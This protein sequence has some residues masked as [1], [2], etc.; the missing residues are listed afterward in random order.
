MR[1][2]SIVLILIVLLASTATKQA[3]PINVNDPNVID[4]AKFA[5]DEY[6]KRKG[7]HIPESKLRLEKVIRGESLLVTDGAGYNLTLSA[8]DGSTS[9]NY[10]AIVLELPVHH[11]RNLTSFKRING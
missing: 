3:K 1:L 4:V 8:T 9:S 2:Q 10:E 11:L 5:V 6:N 7:E